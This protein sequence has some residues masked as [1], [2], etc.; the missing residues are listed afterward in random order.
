MKNRSET[1]EENAFQW[2]VESAEVSPFD[3]DGAD[4]EAESVLE[5]LVGSDDQTGGK[6]SGQESEQES[7]P[8]VAKTGIGDAAKRLI[9]AAVSATAYGGYDLKRGDQDSANRYGGGV[10]SAAAGEALPAQGAKPLDRKSTRLNS[11]HQI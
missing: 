11:S 9:K 2:L 1:I 5:W 8:Q 7:E 3:F 6:T 4:S 10:R